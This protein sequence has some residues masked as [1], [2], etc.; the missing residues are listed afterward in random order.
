MWRLLEDPDISHAYA[1]FLVAAGLKEGRHH[2]PNARRRF[3][4]WLEAAAFT[5]AVTKDEKLNQQMDNIIDV[6]GKAQR[7]DGY[8]H[9]PVIIA[10]N[11]RSKTQS[12]KQNGL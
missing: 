4:K 8:I 10:K 9:T 2:G 1:N 3:Y 12:S 11:N 7:G 5:Y 6:I